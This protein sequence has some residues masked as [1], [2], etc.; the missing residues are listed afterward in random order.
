MCNIFRPIFHRNYNMKKI[1]PRTKCTFNEK[2]V[3]YV[4]VCGFHSLWHC[5]LAKFV[6]QRM[7]IRSKMIFPGTKCTFHET[8]I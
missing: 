7:E 5:F 2:Y 1:F 4:N 6:D 8:Y 3:N